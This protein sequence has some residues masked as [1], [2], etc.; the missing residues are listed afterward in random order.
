[1]INHVKQKSKRDAKNISNSEV[2]VVACRSTTQPRSISDIGAERCVLSYLGA[3]CLGLRGCLLDAPS[4]TMHFVS[5]SPASFL[6]LAI[7]A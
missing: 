5:L 6:V 7:V 4:E 2:C 3:C 1:M